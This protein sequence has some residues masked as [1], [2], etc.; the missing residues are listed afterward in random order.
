[1]SKISITLIGLLGLA[2]A[3]PLAAD[4]EFN[5]DTEAAGTNAT[6]IWL[7]YLADSNVTALE[8]TVE[9]DAP[10]NVRG[11]ARECLASLPKSHRGRCKLEGRFLRG[12]VFSPNNATLPDTNLGSVLLD[13]DSLLKS[14]DGKSIVDIT[15]VEVTTVN[16]QGLSV[17]A[18]VRVSGQLAQSGKKGG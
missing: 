16:A 15:S 13:P 9:L 10:N 1:M 5:V 11:D 4:P 7:S 3:G 6:R 14:A 2:A 18:D 8:F 17:S 12:V